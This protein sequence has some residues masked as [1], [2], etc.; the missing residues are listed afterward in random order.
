[1]SELTKLAG[2]A[3]EFEIGEIKLSIKPLSVSDMD[4][5]MKLGKEGEEQAAAMKELLNKVL[6]ESVPNTTDEEI[7]GISLEYLE[8]IMNAIMEVNQLEGKVD[9]KFLE[10]IKKKQGR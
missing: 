4:L 6:K 8:K 2:K 1:M 10:D 5:M 7:N 9:K 3:K